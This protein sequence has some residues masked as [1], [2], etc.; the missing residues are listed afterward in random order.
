MAQQLITKWAVKRGRYPAIPQRQK[1]ILL[2]LKGAYGLTRKQLMRRLKYSDSNLRKHLKE[3]LERKEIVV[4][5]KANSIEAKRPSHYYAIK[6]N[7]GNPQI[8]LNR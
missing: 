6:G 3:L 4:N 7:Y 8:I 5:Y 1:E 2:C